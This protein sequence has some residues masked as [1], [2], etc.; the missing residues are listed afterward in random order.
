MALRPFSPSLLRMALSIGG[1]FALCVTNAA[2]AQWPVVQSK[3]QFE[4]KFRQLEEILPTPNTYRNAGGAPG[5]AYWQQQ[6]DYSIKVSLDEAERRITSSE[7]ITYTNNSPD[8]LP[9][10]WVQ[11]DQNRFRSDSLAERSADFGGIGNRA[12]ATRSAT[13]NS[14]ARISFSALRKH[15]AEKD[16]DFGF[17]IT[18]VTDADGEALNNTINGTLMRIDLEAPLRPN[19]KVTFTIDWAFN[20]VEENAVSARAGYET[21]DD[22]N[23]IF[24]LAQWYP[25]MAAYSDYEGWHNKEFMG[26]GEFT[27][28]FGDFDVEITV[29]S[30]H[31]VSAS[32][33]LQNPDDV[34]TETHKKRLETAKTAERPV[35]IVTAEEALEAE[36]SKAT[37]MKTWKYRA[38]N[39]RDFAWASSRKF[40]WDA[41]GYEQGGDVQ[42]FVMAM[43]FYPKEGEPLWSRYSTQAVIHTMEVYSRM[44]FDYPYP[45]SQSVNGPVGGMEYPMI[46]FNGPRTELQDDGERTYSAAEKRFLIGVVIHEVGHNYF[47]M[48][49]NSDE[50][51]WTWMD[52]GLN[53][54]LQ[55][56]SEQEWDP[57]Y[58]S[59][60]GEPRNMVSY[61]KSTNQVPIMTNSESILQFGNNAYGKPATALN[62]LRET[63]LGRELFDFA[64]KTYANRWKFKRPTPSD[65]FRT[66]EEASGVD[67]DWFWHGWFYTTDHVDLSIENVVK[68]RLDTEDPD[69]EYKL[70]EDEELKAPVSLTD[71]R[72]AAEKKQGRINDKPWLKDFYDNNSGYLVTNKDRNAYTSMLKGLKDWE[73][74]AL[75][76]AIKDGEH[77]YVVNFANK[78][79]L[80][81]PLILN[82][83]YTDDSTEE[84]R[85]PAEIWRRNAK[86]VSKLLI[87]D[88]EIKDIVLDPNLETADVDLN[89]NYFPRR[90]LP[91]RIEA[92]KSNRKPTLP[93]RDLIQDVKTKLKK[94]G[95]DDDKDS[96]EG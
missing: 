80:V 41:Q 50:R 87:R 81:M 77:F 53:T 19:Q 5:F 61:M 67:L 48:I 15:Q 90:I 95:D 24:L 55:F 44:T 88:K 59:R 22:G 72:N 76:R 20:M 25:R 27:L 45:V 83:T 10:L 17:D 92:Y 66:L 82:I 31:I 33:V 7:T 65:L 23:D 38:E 93:N 74:T 36:K 96:D 13:G 12:P 57:N 42:P 6:A 51:Q 40:I 3:G 32:G 16:N 34:L 8:S 68:M 86:R 78:G 1:A 52:E 49:V 56:V 79:G 62:I 47:P 4:D 26:R 21:F 89:N 91:S 60:R 73:R 46:T 18:A 9:F 29:P 71:Q 11:L 84:Y 30:D 37:E 14:P 69:I 54:F 2:H 43:S 28:E 94:E 39:V 35:F 64:F 70:L 75:E 63:I 85:I 58:R